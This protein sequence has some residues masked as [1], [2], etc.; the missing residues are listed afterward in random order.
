MAWGF[1]QGTAS[2]CVFWHRVR[3]LV[4]SVHGDDFTTAGPRYS[5]DLFEATLEA[6]RDGAP[7]VPEIMLPLVSACREVELVRT[8]IDAV[9]AAVRNERG[10][11]DIV[12]AITPEPVKGH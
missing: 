1:E 3:K 10:R 6:S 8:R 11:E 5:L 4:C 7:V 9:A 2:T 12:A